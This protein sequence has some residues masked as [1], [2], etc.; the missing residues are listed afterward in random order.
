MNANQLP[1]SFSAP[2]FENCDATGRLTRARYA[3]AFELAARVIPLL[4]KPVRDVAALAIESARQFV[5]SEEWRWKENEGRELFGRACA[6]PPRELLDAF[7]RH[8]YLMAGT[9]DD[10]VYKTRTEPRHWSAG[11]YIAGLGSFVAHWYEDRQWGEVEPRGSV[12]YQLN[13]DRFFLPSYK[14]GMRYVRLSESV[15]H[16][17]YCADKI[18]FAKDVASVKPFKF[19]GRLWVNVGG[20]GNV[21]YR[22]GTCW[23]LRPI[24]QW[25]EPRHTYESQCRAVDA[26]AFERGS[27]RG[28]VVSVRGKQYVLDT[29][30]LC[31]DDSV[32][33]AR[34]DDEEESETTADDEPE[35]AKQRPVIPMPVRMTKKFDAFD[36]DGNAL[37]VGSKCKIVS[38]HHP[39]FNDNIGKSVVVGKIYETCVAIYDDRPVRYRVNRAGRS[40]IASDPSNY[41]T[42][43]SA[44]QLQLSA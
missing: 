18:A 12:M 7:R 39:V 11:A 34:S 40:V 33:S 41:Q 23:S 30:L 28:L 2:A 14:D 22:E 19:R 36:V 17:S 27:H 26:R 16:P 4:E 10:A 24:E 44:D 1:L 13:R 42:L 20:S 3:E 31:Y 38:V 6:K 43:I 8:C 35:P 9:A 15:W 21:D 37:A 25:G 29:P 5:D 32:R